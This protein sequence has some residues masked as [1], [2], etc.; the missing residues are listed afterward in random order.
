MVSFWAEAVRVAR[1]KRSGFINPK[2]RKDC[3]MCIRLSLQ[4]LLDLVGLQQNRDY[5]CLNEIGFLC[6]FAEVLLKRVVVQK[7]LR[8]CD[9]N[10]G[11]QNLLTYA[12]FKPLFP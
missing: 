1:R 9:I 2:D 4:G 12:Q 10:I 8:L 5:R 7:L 11:Q 6:L 3:G